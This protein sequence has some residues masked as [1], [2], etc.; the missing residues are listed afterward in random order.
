MSYTIGQ[1]CQ[2]IIDGT[3]YYIKPLSYK[4][5]R[6]RISKYAYRADGTL[7]YV[8]IGPGKRTFSMIL[9]CKNE[10]ANYDGSLSSNTGEQY[11]DAIVSSFTSNIA[12]TISYTDPKGSAINVYFTLYEETILDL[13][14]QVIPLSTGGSVAPSYEILVEMLEA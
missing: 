1:N 9:L 7:S 2:V 6:P 10:L 14:S 13:K 3:G 4:I 11:R 8:D 5:K 12:T